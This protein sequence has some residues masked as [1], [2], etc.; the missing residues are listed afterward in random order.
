MNLAR[1]WTVF[2]GALFALMGVSLASAA[3][4]N[5]EDALSWE[6]QWRTAVGA[7]EPARDEE[8]RRRRL[9]RAY[10]LGGI[11]FAAAGLV[12]LFFAATGRAPIA[13]R[14]P[15]RES[16]FGGIFFTACG[17]VLAINGWLRRGR[18]APRF[19]EGELLAEDAP[20]PPGE[21]V[22]A[23]CS[24]VMIALLFAFGLRLLLAGPR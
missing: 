5:A 24:R 1:E 14:E 4:R 10:R 19:L 22:A 12:L 23:A 16:L 2:A 7:P 3:R 9:V 17:A 11:L 18:R 13:V 15:G 21:R 6:R 20:L 8:P